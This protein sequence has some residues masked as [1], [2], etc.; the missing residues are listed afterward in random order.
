MHKS[1]FVNIIGNPNVGKS[2][3]MNALV[4]ERLSIITAKAQTTRHRIMGIVSGDDF[5][6]V[7]SDTP[8]I[9]KPA[10]KLQESMMKFVDGALTD[11]DIIL[12]VTDTVEQSDRASRVLEN[13]RHCGIPTIVVVNKSTSRIPP[14][15]MRSST[16]GTK[17]SP[18]PGSSP[19]RPANSSISKAFS[20]PSST[21]SQK[22]PP[23][24]PRIPSRT[25]PCA[26]S[27]RRSSARRSSG[28]TTRRSPT[29][30]KSPSTPTRR[31][32][33]S[34]ESPPR[35]SSPGTPRRESSSDTRAKN[36]K[37]S[38]RPHVKTWS[39]SSAKRSS[40]SS[41]SRSATTGG[42]TNDSSAASDTK[43]NS[44]TDPQQMPD[45][46]RKNNK[47]TKKAV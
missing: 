43:R 47:T 45:I 42:T 14:R 29:A 46:P 41:S 36:S 30:A 32:P 3:L 37:G 34:T 6:I 11:A 35:S 4:G 19:S 26:S 9:L 16:S 33:K 18:R 39:S 24:T 40:C 23:S 15:S 22:A 28:S 8:G 13:I 38:G 17:H 27:P 10:Y 20:R 25:R 1:G 7:Y 12:Y 5:Q 44:R 31:S 2:T 21:C